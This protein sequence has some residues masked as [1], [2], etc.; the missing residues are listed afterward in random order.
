MESQ[1]PPGLTAT[2]ENQKALGIN[3]SLMEGHA[4]HAPHAPSYTPPFTLYHLP[5]VSLTTSEVPRE[6]LSGEA[7]RSG[8]LPP[9]IPSSP[10]LI[11]GGGG[12]G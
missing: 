7:A 3:I 4:P 12:T 11:S 6:L 10:P 2:L 5:L 9:S 8:V 1:P